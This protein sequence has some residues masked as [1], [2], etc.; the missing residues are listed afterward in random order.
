MTAFSKLGLKSD[1]NGH[2]VIDGVVDG[3]EAF[4]LAKVVAEAGAGGP[5]LFIARDGQRVADLE[6][7]LNFVQP[8]LPVLQLPAW[9]CLPYDRVSPG[10]DTSA[11]RLAALAGLASLRDH[12][13]PGVILATANA[14]LQKL[15]PRKVLAEQ[16]FMARPGNRIDMNVLVQRL[17][18][19]GFERVPTVRDIGEYAVRGGILDLFAPGA[20]EPL[21]LDFFGDTLETIRTFDPASQ[22]TSSQ[23]T[24]FSMQPMSE[25]TLSPE[26]IS[27]FRTQYVLQFGAPSRDDAL[28]QSI[29]EGRRFAGMEH[30]LPLFYENLETVFDHAG[31]MPVVFDH[32][33]HE[34]MAERHKLVLDHYEAR[35]RQSDGK[36]PGDA[37]PYKP[38][39]PGALYL[40]QEQVEAAAA[41]SGMRVDFTPFDAPFVSGRSVIHA[42][43]HRGRTFVEERSQKETNVFDSV[44]KHIADERACRQE[45][46]GGGV[47]RGYPRPAGT[48][49]E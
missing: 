7:V 45:S 4:A 13:H 11:R 24:E 29:S 30:W 19:N 49:S 5:V 20:D 15:P 46:T 27:H 22:R 14:V 1:T 43:A 47:E 23:K 31:N 8:D 37:V 40:T 25:I 44:V 35:R 34:S 26:I 36:E 39:E 48:G 41:S 18:N 6:Q 38:V 42:G 32:L 2:V 33:A 3:Y 21:R 12:K 9:D 16:L 10:A 17:E 28:Y